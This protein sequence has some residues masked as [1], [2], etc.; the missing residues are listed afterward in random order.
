[1][2]RTKVIYSKGE[3][4]VYLG[5]TILPK[6]DTHIG[7]YK[8]LLT[9]DKAYKLDSDIYT[10]INGFYLV[11]LIDDRNTIGGYEIKIENLASLEENRNS[12]LDS[13]IND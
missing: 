1:M 12:K 5:E 6:H 9:K 7:K 11:H 13:L 2:K 10:D 3:Y 8:S 4:I